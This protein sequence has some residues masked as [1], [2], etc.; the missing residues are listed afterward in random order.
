MKQSEKIW[1]KETE[2]I[3]CDIFCLQA[4]INLLVGYESPANSSP[5]PNDQ[6]N[7]DTSLV[8]AGKKTFN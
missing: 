1:F 7:V 8:E 6:A 4:T 3:I 5:N 2:V